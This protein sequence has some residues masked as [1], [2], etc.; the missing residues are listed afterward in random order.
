MGLKESLYTLA[1]NRLLMDMKHGNVLDVDRVCI[2]HNEKK[3]TTKYTIEKN[4]QE[5]K[6]TSKD[7]E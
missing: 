1:R 5:F 4:G 7:F 3:G 2:K 6:F